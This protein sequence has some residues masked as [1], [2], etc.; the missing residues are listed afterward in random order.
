VKFLFIP[1]TVGGGLIAGAISKK[2]FEALWGLVDDQE[3]PEAKHREIV[4]PKLIAAL[5]LQGAV[6]RLMRG[7][8]DHWSRRGFLRL[9]GSWPGEEAPEPE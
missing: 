6:F 4:F 8:V 5:V 7:L 1:F 2:I 3:P 9:T